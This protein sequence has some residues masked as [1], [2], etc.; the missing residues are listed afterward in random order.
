M[1][2]LGGSTPNIGKKISRKHYGTNFA[3]N[4]VNIVCQ[5]YDFI[6][7]LLISR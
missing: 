4:D 2:T 5:C 1:P 7:R 3:S 6:G